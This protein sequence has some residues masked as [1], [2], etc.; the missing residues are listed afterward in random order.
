M[1][2]QTPAEVPS[3]LTVGGTTSP[4]SPPVSSW[5]TVQ[6]CL[7]CDSSPARWGAFEAVSDRG[8]ALHY[9]RC[10]ECGLVFMNPR[11]GASSLSDFYAAEYRLQVQGREDPTSKD[12]WA[13]RQRAQHMLELSRP[14]VREVRRHLDIGSSLGEMLAAFH[15]EHT[16]E[17]V[18][19][20]PGRAYRTL[21]QEGGQHVYPDLAQ[22]PPESRSSYDLI[23][24]AHVLEHLPDPLMY[25]QEIR[26]EWLSPGGILVAEV[27][28]LL[29]HPSLEASHLTAYDSMSIQMLLQAA[30][31]RV[32]MTKTHG[33]PHS[34]LL[35]LFLFIVA[36]ACGD[37]DGPH[38]EFRP[39]RALKLRRRLGL[40]VLQ[41][42]RALG[43]LL[44]GK[45]RL[46]PWE[47]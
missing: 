29:G 13:Q 1:I 19:V 21:S 35:P 38:P 16:C 45:R 46:S 5:E 20:E 24:M 41:T 28:N 39:V 18:G 33:R 6:Q 23:T 22:L 7:L 12:R 3:E 25:L 14:L 42:A 31:Y 30:G 27:P 26:E 17:S 2:A 44:L 11:P 34:R 15:K 36:K 8:S 10:R 32:L 43:L 37:D 9:V 4:K 40:L 47:G